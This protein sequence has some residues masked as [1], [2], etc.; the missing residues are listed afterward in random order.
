MHLASSHIVSSI[1]LFA[2]RAAT[3]LAPFAIFLALPPFYISIWV[4]VEGTMPW[5]HTIAALAALGCAALAA[6]GDPRARAALRHPLVLIPAGLFGLAVVLLPA[7]TLPALSL[8]GAPEHGFGALAFLDLAALTAA[9]FVALSDSTWKRVALGVTFVTVAGAFILD[10]LFRAKATWAPFFFG[11]YLAFYAVL[12]FAILGVLLG[13]RPFA[14]AAASLLCLFLVVL[15]SNKGAILAVGGASVLL[16]FF[17]RDG[18]RRTAVFFSLLMPFIVGGAIVLVGSTFPEDQRGVLNAVTG[19]GS[20]PVLLVDSW[21]SLWSRAMLVVVASYSFFDEP[22]RLLTGFGWGHY[23]ESLLANLLVVQGR[24]HEYIGPSHV[25][26]DAIRRAD[27]HSHNQYFEALLSSGI[28][29]AGLFLAYGVAGVIYA[30][31]ER[32]RLALFVVLTLVTLQ[33]FWFQMPHTVPV[34]AIAMAVLVGAPPMVRA[35]RRWDYIAVAGAS[36]CCLVLIVGAFVAGYVSRNISAERAEIDRIAQSGAGSFKRHAAAGLR[37]IYDAALI[38]QAFGLARDN[39]DQD[40]T[41]VLQAY[42]A[43]SIGGEGPKTLKFSI[44]VANALSGLFFADPDFI[45]RIG[46][47]ERDFRRSIEH[48]IRLAPRRADITIPYFN[49]LLAAGREGEALELANIILA[50]RP[51]DAVALWFSGIV[52]LGREATGVAGMRNLRR[53]LAFGVR[54]LMPIDEALVREIEQ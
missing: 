39:S 46:V 3:I 23:N 10:A 51:D 9:A 29:G 43:P 14:F 6:I 50:R 32:R 12:V 1:G 2:V 41:T 37:E 24:L 52:L 54:N 31:I 49:F 4:Q 25:Y 38:Q 26:W 47:T 27:F 33:S 15:S 44:S 48:V 5:L 34:M 19:F 8:L 16:P 20:L 53:S 30:P 36:A 35:E 21:A 11:D 42:L 40:A 18:P 45:A 17:W 22:W 13:R 7:T 28:A